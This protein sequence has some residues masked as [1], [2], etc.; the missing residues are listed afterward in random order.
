MIL[1]SVKS[2]VVYDKRQFKSNSAAVRFLKLIN[3]LHDDRRK[4]NGWQKAKS[5]R[6]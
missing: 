6:L 1:I 4:C 2:K 3:R 5:K